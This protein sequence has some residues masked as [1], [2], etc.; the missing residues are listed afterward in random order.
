MRVES[1]CNT[2]AEFM[3]G[4]WNAAWRWSLRG[5]AAGRQYPTRLHLT[6]RRLAC[7][8][9]SSSSYLWWATCVAWQGG[10]THVPSATSAFN[11]IGADSALL[12]RECGVVASA[13]SVCAWQAG[14]SVDGGCRMEENAHDAT[15][16]KG[17]QRAGRVAGA[18]RCR[19]LAACLG[20]SFNTELLLPMVCCSKAAPCTHG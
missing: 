12:E 13:A 8:R 4:V 5:R 14:L 10:S 3:G 20:T 19:S 2:S 18:P 17:A 16:G 6:A 11:G 15:V 1:R 9:R 7:V